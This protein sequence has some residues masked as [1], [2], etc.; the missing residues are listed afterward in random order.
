MQLACL[1]FFIVLLSAIVQSFAVGTGKISASLCTDPPSIHLNNSL[2]YELTCTHPGDRLVVEWSHYGVYKSDHTASELMDAETGG[3]CLP[4]PDDCFMDHTSKVA[5]LCTGHQMCLISRRPQ[6][7]HKCSEYSN[8]LYI[9]YHCI[10]VEST[11]YMCTSTGLISDNVFL[12]SPGFPK[13]YPP[14][15]KCECELTS[16]EM[17]TLQI[18]SVF[19]STQEELDILKIQQPGRTNVTVSGPAD[20]NTLL[21]FTGHKAKVTFQSDKSVGSAGFVLAAKALGVCPPGYDGIGSMCVQLY[22]GLHNWFDY[23]SHCQFQGDTALSWP[24]DPSDIKHILDWLKLSEVNEVWVE[25]RQAPKN[26][27][28]AVDNKW[29]GIFPPSVRSGKCLV[30]SERRGFEVVSCHQNSTGVCVRN[31]SA[32]HFP[33]SVRC[34]SYGL[35]DIY[36]S[37]SM[38][39]ED[40]LHVLNKKRQLTSYTWAM[41][42]QKRLAQVQGCL[43]WL[44]C[45][46]V[47]LVSL[48]LIICLTCFRKTLMLPKNPPGSDLLELHKWGPD[49][50]EPNDQC[51]VQP[52]YV[53]FAKTGA[54]DTYCSQCLRKVLPVPYLPFSCRSTG[55]CKQHVYERVIASFMKRDESVRSGKNEVISTAGPSK[56]GYDGEAKRCTCG[57]HHGNVG[58]NDV[59]PPGEITQ[60]FPYIQRNQMCSNLSAE[61]GYSSSNRQK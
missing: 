59:T 36:A 34:N 16:S 33:V 8:Y 1:R 12:L 58:A 2:E 38:L 35:S 45:T 9:S 3:E 43:F 24:T 57:C 39:N 4:Q 46:C 18:S 60:R 30:H 52:Y 25:K 10:P 22:S 61:S 21:T 47:A 11:E 23:N 44:L 41:Y 15:Q 26:G 17:S 7:V 31:R 54:R 20:V 50:S 27:E 5:E 28:D 6:L 14:N 42:Q 48:N 56:E 32:Q 40:N 55:S 37:P 13:D 29:K 49:C 53:D 19:F 51:S